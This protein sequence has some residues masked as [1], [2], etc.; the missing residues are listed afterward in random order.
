MTAGYGGREEKHTITGKFRGIDWSIQSVSQA[1]A[2]GRYVRG[3]KHGDLD[4]VRRLE[5]AAAGVWNS[6][7][8]NFTLVLSRYYKYSLDLIL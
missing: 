2:A 4:A 7:F 6:A 1:A 8:Y 3:E 5:M